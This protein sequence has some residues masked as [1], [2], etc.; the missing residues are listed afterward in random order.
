MNNTIKRLDEEIVL[1]EGRFKAAEEDKDYGKMTGLNGV[2]AGLRLARR[3][4]KFGV[5]RGSKDVPF[6]YHNDIRGPGFRPFAENRFGRIRCPHYGLRGHD[7][8]FAGWSTE[9]GKTACLLARFD[10]DSHE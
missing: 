4:V 10:E 5:E 1:M 2:L 3:L 9:C 6:R 8:Y 7:C